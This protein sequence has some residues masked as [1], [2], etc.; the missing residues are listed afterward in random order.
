MKLHPMTENDW[1]VLERWYTDSE[2]LYYSERDNVTFRTPDE[3]RN[4]YRLVSQNA[5]CFMNEAAGK[6]VGECWL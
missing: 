1:D 2:I 6:T 5:Y 3:V 4:K